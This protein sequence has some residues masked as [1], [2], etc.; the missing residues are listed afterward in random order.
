MHVSLFNASQCCRGVRWGC[1]GSSVVQCWPRIEESLVENDLHLTSSPMFHKR[2]E[3]LRLASIWT[4]TCHIKLTSCDIAEHLLEEVWTK[5]THLLMLCLAND[6]GVAE[7]ALMV[8]TPWICY[9]LSTSAVYFHSLRS[10]SG[11][12][13]VIPNSSLEPLETARLLF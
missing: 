12:N 2:G 11:C 3:C 6:Q 4:W 10:L 1:V 5:V 13:H 9:C 7:I 8:L